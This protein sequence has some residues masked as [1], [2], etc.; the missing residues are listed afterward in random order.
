MSDFSDEFI[1]GQIACREGK[2]CPEGASESFE[3]GF[4]TEHEK[5]AI[6]A[7][8]SSLEEVQYGHH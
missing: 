7:E 5:E 6:Q 2:E 4:G 1:R 3:R 8:L